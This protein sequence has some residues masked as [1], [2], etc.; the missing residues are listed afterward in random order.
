MTY[1]IHSRNFEIGEKT[2]TKIEER[3]KKLEKLFPSNVHPVIGITL[4]KSSYTAEITLMVSKRIARAETVDTD[5]MAAI[6]K[7]CETIEKQI[8]RYKGRMRIKM[9]KN[10]AL[11]AEY[12]SIPVNEEDLLSDE[13][14]KIHIERN[15]K[16][17]L[18]PMDPEEA[19]MQMELLDHTF[20]V[21]MN[22]VTNEI[23][24]VYKRKNNTYGL[25]EPDER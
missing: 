23:N 1:T 10:D 9:R 24:V 4:E 20:F 13:T 8:I 7:A 14:N 6:D 19:I 18:R 15:K 17:E 21:F 22:S 11:K 3:V 12:D 5:M 16:F 25:I 2:R